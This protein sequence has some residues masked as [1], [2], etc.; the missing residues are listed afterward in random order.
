MLIDTAVRR[1][2]RNAPDILIPGTTYRWIWGVG[3]IARMNIFRFLS[4][5]SLIATESNFILRLLGLKCGKRFNLIDSHIYDP[6]IV[7]V[8]E[9]VLVGTDATIGEHFHPFRGQINRQPIV[10][11]NNCL[12]GGR[13]VIQNGVTIED[14]VV[15]SI[16]S[17]VPRNTVLESGWIYNGV[18]AQKVRKINQ[19]KEGED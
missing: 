1:I 12:I 5:I 13:T 7:V 11:G 9:N 17:V 3:A 14:N 18:P 6:S 19:K 2:L 16:L 8:G 15:L 10:I 4:G